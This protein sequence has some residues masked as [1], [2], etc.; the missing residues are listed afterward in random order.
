[1]SL[2]YSDAAGILA[3]VVNKKKGLK[4]AVYADGI[5]N[6]V[7]V[8]RSWLQAGLGFRAWLAVRVVRARVRNTQVQV[9]Y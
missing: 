6:K 7:C 3:D 4:T 5:S 9:C 8:G 1:M 2:L